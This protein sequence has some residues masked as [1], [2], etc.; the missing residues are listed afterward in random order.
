MK[1]ISFKVVVFAIA[2]LMSST[3]YAVGPGKGKK[4]RYDLRVGGCHIEVITVKWKLDSLMGEPTVNGSFRWDGDRDCS[5]PSSTKIY[6]K[7]EADNNTYGYVEIS[8]VIP[9]SDEGFGYN[10]T[11]SPNWDNT[12]CGAGRNH[13][14]DCWDSS[15]AKWLWKNGSVTDFLIISN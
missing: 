4:T 11:G 1:N 9:D 13:R 3:L 6:L 12:I 5:L 8:P 7:V 2:I 14:N 15:D 10:V